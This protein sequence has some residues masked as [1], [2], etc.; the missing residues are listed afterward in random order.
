MDDIVANTGEVQNFLLSSSFCCWRYII[1]HQPKTSLPL[2]CPWFGSKEVALF[3]SRRDEVGWRT[4]EFSTSNAV[5]NQ[6]G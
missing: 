5:M 4:L 1:F 6:I 3:A 2:Y